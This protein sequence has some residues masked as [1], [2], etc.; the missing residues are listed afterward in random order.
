MAEKYSGNGTCY[1]CGNYPNDDGFCVCG[2]DTHTSDGSEC[3]SFDTWEELGSDCWKG[4]SPISIQEI[5]VNWTWR[6]NEARELVGIYILPSQGMPIVADE[7]RGVFTV[8]AGG[9][10]EPVGDAS[11][12]GTILE[13]W[14]ELFNE[15]S[16]TWATMRR[17]F[18][19]FYSYECETIDSEGNKVEI[20]A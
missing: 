10:N 4:G 7:G 19:R 6:I 3:D 18:E 12:A 16:Q 1:F 8:G 13:G 2:C 15:Q 5:A 9:W 17:S 14:Q 20:D 11:D